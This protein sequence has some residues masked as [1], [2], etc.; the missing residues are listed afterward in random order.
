MPASRNQPVFQK[1][2]LRN[3]KGCWS[4]TI[5]QLQ[6]L[7]SH[8]MPC[9]EESGRAGWGRGDRSPGDC[10]PVF[11]VEFPS[12]PALRGSVLTVHGRFLYLPMTDTSFPGGGSTGSLASSEESPGHSNCSS[13]THEQSIQSPASVTKSG[14]GR[15]K[16]QSR[17]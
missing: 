7:G 12:D 1:P 14:S 4:W 8:L 6:P 17:V 13:S 3:S 16:G 2:M 9:A 15:V 5:T 10:T 11:V